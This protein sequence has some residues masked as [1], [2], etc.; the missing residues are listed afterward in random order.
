M[1]RKLII[2]CF[3]ALMVATFGFT[4]CSE[5]KLDDTIFDSTV[6]PLDRTAYTFPLDTFLKVNF[7]EPYNLRFVYR[8]EDVGSDMNKNLVPASYEKCCQLAVLTKYLW[9]DV[10]K[11][12]AGEQFLKL[13]S[14]RIIHVIGSKNINAS[15][16][17]EV[18]GVTEGGVKITLY[19][20]NGL[21]ISNLSLM[22]DYFF[23]TMHHEFGHVLDQNRLHP[24]D[25]NTISSGHYNSSSWQETSDSISLGL[26]FIT[27]YG[28]SATS[29]DWV[30]LIAN[31]I[32][33]SPADWNAK[34]NTASYEWEEIDYD[35]NYMTKRSSGNR[36]T[37]GYVY[38]K[39]NGDQKI[40]RRKCLRDTETD[41]CLL[42]SKGEVQWS[43]ETGIDGQAVIL[44][45]LAMVRDWLKQYFNAN[46]DAIRQEVHQRQFV[47]DANGEVQYDYMGGFATPKNKLTE[48]QSDGRTFME[49]LLDEVE[50][51]KALQPKE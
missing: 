39:Q 12:H 36:D 9:Y 16:G 40:V 51:Y 3:A 50:Q 24:T 10:Y 49:H 4:S 6:Y 44:R 14:P 34:L 45:K 29:E 30:E 33:L 1:N 27:S 46:L 17:T 2:T 35:Q 25:F 32:I 7:L 38:T 19:N 48:I 18:A 42:D 22:N 31:Y 21:N 47:T 43:H 8:M 15:Q 37:V 11:K 28:S 26:G 23:G 5:D 41:Y 13:Y 20:T